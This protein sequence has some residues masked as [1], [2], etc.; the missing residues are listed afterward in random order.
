MSGTHR[1]FCS[2]ELAFEA[3]MAGQG[4]VKELE[5]VIARWLGVRFAVTV[6]SGTLALH[7]ALKAVGVQPG[8]EVIVAAYDWFAATAAVLHCGAIPVF[9]D[10]DERTYTI[11]PCAVAQ[12]LSPQTKAITATH[13]FGHPA[14]MPQLR[15]LADRHGVA[16]IEDAAHALGAVCD[17]KKVGAWGDL[18]CFSFGV[19]KVVSCGEGGLIAT[20][21]ESLYE[22]VLALCQHPLRQRWEGLVPNPFALK[23]PMNPLAAAYLL[24]QWDGLEQ[25]LAERQRAFQRL[26]EVLAETEVLRPVFVREGCVHAGYR[27]C[28]VVAK[29]QRTAIVQALGEAGIPAC[30]GFLAQPLP[31]GLGMA[32][33]SGQLG[34]HPFPERLLGSAS[35]P[36]PVANRLCRTLITLDGTVGQTLEGLQTLRETLRVLVTLR[37]FGRKEKIGAQKRSEEGNLAGIA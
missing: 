15:E 12:R 20:D 17:G 29:G 22:R 31:Q 19:G 25:K 24:E 16:L 7:I 18:A 34:W 8:D 2:D 37:G 21:E 33:R 32:L 1:K 23:A 26:N 30:A 28:P 5:A 3:A 11:D 9:A 6:S 35:L 13:L 10:V 27:F 14:E 4:A 36:C